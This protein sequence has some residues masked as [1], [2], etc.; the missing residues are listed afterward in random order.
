MPLGPPSGTPGS[1]RPHVV[2]EASGTRSGSPVTVGVEW[3]V[4]SGADVAVVQKQVGDCFDLTATGASAS[5]TT[6]SR[7]ILMNQGMTVGFDADDRMG[8][9]TAVASGRD[10]G[11]KSDNRGTNLIGV[12]QLADVGATLEWDAAARYGRLSV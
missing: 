3:L 5:P 11:V 7:A 4:D 2:G 1:Q 6:G 8:G 12:D 10:V 9:V